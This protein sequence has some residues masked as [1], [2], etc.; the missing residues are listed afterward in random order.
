MTAE[1]EFLPSPPNVPSAE[2]KVYVELRICMSRIRR[3]I[4]RRET[5]RDEKEP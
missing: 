3:W 5:P 4:E 1:P 2:A